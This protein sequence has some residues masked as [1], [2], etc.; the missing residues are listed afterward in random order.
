[1]AGWYQQAASVSMALLVIPLIIK[2]LSPEE[3][4]IWFTFQAIFLSFGV[5][6][7]GTG[8]T[9]AR[10]V[11][12]SKR[13][14]SGD[15][16][17]H[18][19]D[20]IA[21]RHGW[22]G[23]TD[24]CRH[25]RKIFR[26]L[27]VLALVILVGLQQFILP[28]GDL[29]PNADRSYTIAWYL[30]SATSLILLYTDHKKVILEGIGMVYLNRLAMGTQFLLGGIATFLA[31]SFTGSLVAMAAAQLSAG[32]VLVLLV[33]I[34]YRK[35][36]RANLLPDPGENEIKVRDL[37]KVA[38]PLGVMQTGG[39]LSAIGRVPLIGFL[40]GPAAVSPFFIAEKIGIS[41]L[42][43]VDHLQDPQRPFFTSEI[44]DQKWQ[45]ARKRMLKIGTVVTVVAIMT[46]AIFFL[47]ST[48]F[49][50]LWIG[51]GRYVDTT[52]LFWMA[53]HYCLGLSLGTWRSFTLASGRNPFVAVTLISGALSLTLCLFLTPEFGVIG[54]VWSGLIAS[55]LTGYWFN[56][57][58]GIK[59]WRFLTA[60]LGDTRMALG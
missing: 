49:V 47:G 30:L 9:I 20:F 56:I 10:Q 53:L 39:F 2:V 38:L 58:H 16:I 12:Y 35:H 59:L 48:A 22:A 26:F 11:A 41:L 42:L 27:T 60:K 43:A 36:V 52:V 18:D 34:A 29:L 24:L 3:A 31:L 13:L 51:P 21:T 57:Y 1:M 32:A 50:N 33:E 7:F 54:V 17:P 28:L 44:A 37:L 15:P 19:C 45:L 40:L 55:A 4:G 25:S 5:L 8:F 14:A 46:Q 23:I 6:Q